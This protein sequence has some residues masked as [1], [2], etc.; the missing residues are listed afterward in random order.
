MHATIL[1][2]ALLLPTTAMAGAWASIDSSDGIETFRKEVEGSAMMA[3]R[4]EAETDVPVS[5]LVSV[6][7]DPSKGT[8]WVDLLIGSELVRR[9][10][11]NQILLYNQYDLSWP[12]SDRDYVMKRVA[13]FDPEQKVVTVAYTSVIDP[14]KPEQECCVRATVHRTFWRFSQLDARRSRVE[15]EVHTDPKGSLPAWVVNMV[16]KGWPKNSITGLIARATRD[17]VQPHPQAADW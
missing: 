12:I 1:I 9:D 11:P 17:D 10:G 15:V 6:L 4:G 7:L 3:F 5:R 16:Q 14:L 2:A 13:S 8:E